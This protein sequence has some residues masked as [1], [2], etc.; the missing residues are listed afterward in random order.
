MPGQDDLFRTLPTTARLVTEG[1][2]QWHPGAQLY[3]SRAG[4]MLVDAAVGF[5]QADESLT[6]EHRI[7]WL[8]AGKPLTAFAMLQQ[9]DEGRLTLDTPVAS[10]IPE[11]A[12]NGKAGITLRHLLTH[13]AG[14]QPAPTGWPRLSWDEII[15]RV[16]AVKLRHGAIAGGTPAYDPQRTWFI[17]GEWLQRLT[18]LEFDAAV[19]AAVFNPLGMTS[20]SFLLSPARMRSRPLAKLHRCDETGCRLEPEGYNDDGPPSPGSTF[21][22]PARELGRFYELLLHE[23]RWRGRSLL[24]ADL[25]REMTARQRVDEFDLTFQHR[26]DFGLGF[27]IDSNHHGRETVPYGFGR[28]CSPD[29]FGHGGAECAMAFADPAHELVVALAMNGRPGE[30]THQYRNREV[31][32]AIYVDLGLA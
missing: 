6:A 12:A 15:A 9:V 25:V 16:C 11:F 32:S 20:S 28:Q 22:A 21:R 26:V 14:L 27:V 4:E 10:A 8:S 30:A 17:L 5:A 31:C 3:I 24:S 19:Q 2:G 18:G 29:T 7:P 13:T 1:L 23:G